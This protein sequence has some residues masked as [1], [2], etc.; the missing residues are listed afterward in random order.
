[1]PPGWTKRRS[2]RDWIA[3]IMLAIAV[4]LALPAAA[5]APQA[6]P[7]LTTRLGDLLQVL[8]G[9]GDYDALFSPTFRTA[10]PQAE[11][12]KYVAQL[13]ALGG[14][15][16]GVD[17]VEPRTPWAATV[18]IGY[19]GS[20][21]TMQ[22]AVDPAGTHQIT[23]LRITGSQPRDDSIARLEADFRKLPGASGFGI[24]T[25]GAGEVHPVVEANG[26]I[27]APLGSAF[28]LWVLAEA[29]RE[30]SAGER[31]W[32]D[33]IRVGP[34]SLPSGILQTWPDRAPVTLQTLA[35]LMISI[36]D[37][38]AA[39]TLLTTLGRD[40][41][42]QMVAA[43][44][45]ADPDRTLPLLTTMQAFALKSPA[46][47]DLAAAWQAAKT[48][49]DRTTL[50]DRDGARLAAT[51]ID[52]HMFD[53]KPLAIDSIEWFASPRDMAHVL[54]WLRVNGD[55]TTRAILAVNPGTDPT[56]AAHFDYIGFKGGS[57]PGVITLNFLVRTRAGVWMA[58]TG[59]WH[60]PAA[61]VGSLTFASLMNR[62]LL[63]AAAS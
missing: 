59:N 6:D 7:A 62:A 5:Q 22:I 35:T 60:D 15:A 26:T 46:N 49:G 44:G 8:N 39:D 38:T 24:Y 4:L 50:L 54:D 17:A 10:V 14:T 56:T 12:A 57:E 43:I 61:P 42:G 21:A 37:N 33:V 16:T 11:F 20:V 27:P 48:A 3:A 2:M 53:A 41:V 47:A 28:K 51:R 34:K 30:V 1:M 19:T 9:A 31:Q 52:P 32:S 58:I 45:V 36:S 63:L 13:R 25:L 18:Q 29:S 40:K 23:G 55:D